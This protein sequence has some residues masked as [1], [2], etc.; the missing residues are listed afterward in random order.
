MNRCLND[1]FSYCTGKP[2]KVMKEEDWSVTP[3]VENKGT[4]IITKQALRCTIN[5]KT[6]KHILKNSDM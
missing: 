6:C 2:R 4:G 5:T 3:G 1:M